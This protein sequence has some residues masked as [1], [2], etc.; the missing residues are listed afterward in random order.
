MKKQEFGLRN[1]RGNID[2][3][4]RQNEF[5]KNEW[6]MSVKDTDDVIMSGNKEELIFGFMAFCSGNERILDTFSRMRTVEIKPTIQRC[7]DITKCFVES[8]HALLKSREK[9]TKKHEKI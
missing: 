3:N 7:I 8:R 5:R 6:I 2:I 4:I 9:L 1:H